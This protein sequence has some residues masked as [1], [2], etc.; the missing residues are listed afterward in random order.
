MEI[1]RRHYEQQD[2]KHKSPDVPLLVACLPHKLA[3]IQGGCKN[4]A[5]GLNRG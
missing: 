5:G 1:E 4:D 2:Q 3:L